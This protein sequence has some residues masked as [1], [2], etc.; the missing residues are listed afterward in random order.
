MIRILTLLIP[1]GLIMLAGYFLWTWLKQGVAAL[2]SIEY[3]YVRYRDGIL[4]LKKESRGSEEEVQF[5][6]GESWRDLTPRQL[7]ASVGNVDWYLYPSGHEVDA[8][9][10]EEEAI[11]R[12][13]RFANNTGLLE[14]EI[15]TE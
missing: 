11:H 12:C 8:A 1:A 5:V 4:T 15:L 2:T 3:F 6:P 10:E 9:S 14:A 13:L 7:A